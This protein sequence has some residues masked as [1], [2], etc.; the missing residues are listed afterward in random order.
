MEETYFLL[1]IEYLT[2]VRRGAE[3]IIV[4]QLLCGT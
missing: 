1:N 2:S 3:V 4:L